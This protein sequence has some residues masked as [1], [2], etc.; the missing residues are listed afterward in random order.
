[1][2]RSGHHENEHAGGRDGRLRGPAG[3]AEAR[4]GSEE[5][6]P[7]ADGPAAVRVARVPGGDERPLD[8]EASRSAARRSRAS[9]G[10]GLAR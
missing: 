6:L 2:S 7:L 10:P 1:M 8:G 9:P 5:N 4:S 3:R